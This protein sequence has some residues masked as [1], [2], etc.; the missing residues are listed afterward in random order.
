[1]AMAMKWFRV[2]W[3]EPGDDLLSSEFVQ[4][5]T[6]RGAEGAIRRKY[7][8]DVLIDCVWENDDSTTSHLIAM[9]ID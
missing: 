8:N 1:M 9:N 2:L 5:K 4:A 7:G 6:R 3:A